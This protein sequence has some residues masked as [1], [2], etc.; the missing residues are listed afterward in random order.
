MN[1]EAPG[2]TRGMKKYRQ[3]GLSTLSCF[4]L[5]FPLF[6][7]FKGGKTASGTVLA[8]GPSHLFELRLPLRPQKVELDPRNWVLSGKTES[9]KK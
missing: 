7:K 9:R 1:A 6:L 2:A 4:L 5:A 8:Y 3:Q